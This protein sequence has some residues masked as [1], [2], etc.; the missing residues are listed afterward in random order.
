[1]RGWYAEVKI[2]FFN[3]RYSGDPQQTWGFN[4]MRNISK[5]ASRGQWKPHLPEWDNTT[6]MSQMGDIHNINNISSGRKLELRPYA[7][8]GSSKTVASG[9]TNSIDVGGDVR[10]SPS[11]NLTADFTLNP[12]FAQVDADVYEINL[13]RFPTRFKELRPFFTE[14]INVFN[15]PLELFYSR[16]IGAQRKILAGAK[17]TGKLNH[18]FE[19]GVLGNQT[20]TSFFSDSE[21]DA[22]KATYGVF[23]VKKD[24]FGS[25][26]VGV[27]GAVKEEPD[28]YNRVFGI[29]GNFI[30]GEHDLVE[31]QVA[32]GSTEQQFTHNKAYN[33]L[34]THTGD[35]WGTTVN[36]DRVEPSFEINEIG[37]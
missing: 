7:V 1:G 18:G 27:L 16:R 14:R 24:V 22:G 12:D 28:N 36:Y 13:T 11:P 35:L 23:R 20:G 26:S 6:R 3:F 8:L 21:A 19:F 25:G 9:T 37:Y 15:T 31:F 32:S 2:P 4:I 34:Y 10:Y 5:N 17:M 33:F 30:L 29:D